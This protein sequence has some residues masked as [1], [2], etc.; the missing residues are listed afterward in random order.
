MNFKNKTG[1]ITFDEISFPKKPNSRSVILKITR[2]A[3]I[4]IIGFDLNVIEVGNITIGMIHSELFMKVT[5]WM[6]IRIGI[7]GNNWIIIQTRESKFFTI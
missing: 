4:I 3:L 1:V 5:L 7:N 2:F 6:K